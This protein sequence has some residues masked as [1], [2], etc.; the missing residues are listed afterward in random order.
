MFSPEEMELKICGAPHIN[1]DVLHQNVMYDG[2]AETEPH[3]T[4]LWEV[5]EEFDQE[6]RALFLQFVWARSRLPVLSSQLIM[7]F[8]IQGAPDSVNAK[9][10]DHLPLAHTCFFSIAV[11]A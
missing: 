7:K 1:L 2:I 9:P 5:L 4:W 11:P 3:V 6:Q 8:K 10:D